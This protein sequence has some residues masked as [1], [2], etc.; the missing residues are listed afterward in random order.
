MNYEL[1][2][3]FAAKVVKYLQFTKFTND[4][5]CFYLCMWK[6]NTTFAT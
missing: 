4:Y 5:L 2:C 3:K 1:L 6:K